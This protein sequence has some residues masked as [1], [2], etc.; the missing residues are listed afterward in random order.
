MDLFEL[1][2]ALDRHLPDDQ[3]PAAG[4][5]AILSP[6]HGMGGG[7]MMHGPEPRISII[8]RVFNEA[9]HLERLLLGIRQQ[10]GADV[11]VVVVDS[12][13]TDGS[14]A[15]AARFGARILTIR[16]ED[17][18]FGRSLNIGVEAARGNLIVIASGHVFPVYPDWLEQLTRPFVDPQIALVYGRQRGGP[19]TRFSERQVFTQWF[20]D[21]SELRQGTPFCNNANAA[22][23]REVWERRRYSEDLPG[24]EDLEWA[25]W[26]QS[27]GLHVAYSAEAEVVHIHE[28]SLGAI[29]NRYRREG[30]ALKLIRP[31]ENFRF[32][33][34][35]R[36][37]ATNIV[38]DLWHAREARGFVR[39][40]PG[41]LGFRLMQ[42]WGTYQGFRHAGP[43]TSQLKRT[44]YYPRGFR[45]HTNLSGRNLAPIDYESS[46]KQVSQTRSA[47]GGPEVGR[48]LG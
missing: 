43:L 20:P 26:A 18:S 16:P 9:R 34:F 32:A 5:Q 39:E 6:G 44:F 21:R 8:V 4:E 46:L 2:A 28:E 10:P 31:Q 15:I 45:A 3:A 23:R 29:F 41:I 1:R 35:T 11:E 47:E 12:G 17:F 36:L 30:M 33:D 37:V 14:M 7:S 24:L 27:Q 40:A 25:T 22:I 48:K 38:S 42:F 19:G 13:S